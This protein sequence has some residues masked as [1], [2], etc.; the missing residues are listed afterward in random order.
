MALATPELLRSLAERYQPLLVF[1]T[2]ERVFPAQVESYLSHV[3]LAAWAPGAGQSAARDLGVASES[4]SGARS[5]GTAIIQGPPPGTRLGGPST[6]GAPLRRDGHNADSIGSTAYK[7]RWAPPGLFLTFGGWTDRSCT[8]GDRAY[9]LAAFGELTAAMEPALDWAEFETLPNRPLLWVEQ[10]TAPTIYA[11]AEW[12][13]AYVAVDNAVDRSGSPARD[14]A[15]PDPASLRRLLALTYHVFFPVLDAPEGNALAFGV[16]A[17]EGQWE[18]ATVFLPATPSDSGDPAELDVTEPPVAVALSRDRG[19]QVRLS[20]C[21]AWSQVS[22]LG[23]HPRLYVSRGRHQ[24][25]FAPPQDQV[26]NYDGPGGGASTNT[27]LDATDPGQDDFPGSEVLLLGL[28]LPFPLNLLALLA[29]IVS[30]LLGLHNDAHNG[31]AGPPPDI[32]N[33]DGDGGGS[34]ASPTDAG[35][36][37]EVLPDGE[38]IDDPATTLLRFVDRLR[39]DP[40]ET[41]WPDDDDPGAPPPPVEQPFWWDFAGRWGVDVVVGATQWGPGTV[42]VDGTNR[43]MGYWNT[44]RLTVAWARGLIDRS[45]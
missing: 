20:S 29:W 27:R 12:C 38:R 11:E 17:R 43:S 10:P 40:P 19:V 36:A 9:L 45:V 1:S 4:G 5:R 22:R 35:R 30:V 34:V 42:R 7:P 3:S 14:F 18:A 23:A 28:L 2:G 37:G 44:V 16:R 32:S 41:S 24:L 26:G 25:L 15:G 6:A 31:E 21:R 33:P 13:A 8:S 39:R